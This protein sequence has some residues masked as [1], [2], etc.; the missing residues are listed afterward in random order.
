[1]V[2]VGRKVWEEMVVVVKEHCKCKVWSR[3]QA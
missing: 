3:M 2:E 1:M